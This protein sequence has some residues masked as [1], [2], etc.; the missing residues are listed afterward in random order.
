[1]NC[2]TV[3]TE[4]HIEPDAPLVQA[5]LATCQR[6]AA[7]AARFAR[8]DA[9]LRPELVVPAPV[10][11]TSRVEATVAL[12]LRLEAALRAELIV[13]APAALTVRLLNLVP[14]PARIASTVDVVVRNALFVQAPPDLTARL[15]DLVPHTTATPVPVAPARPRRWVVATVYFITAALVLLS[16]VY[17]GQVYSAVATQFGLQTWLGQIA[18]LPATLLEQLYTYVP[19]SRIVV[20]TVVRLQQPLQWLLVALVLWAI[21]DMTQRQSQR[22]AEQKRQYA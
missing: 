11:L 10:T 19:Q 7:Y 5:H 22:Q 14:E 13:P 16:M 3:R 8:L 15:L 21:F 12:P 4:V 17:A 9:V 20:G 18:S 1:M 2:Q 6:C